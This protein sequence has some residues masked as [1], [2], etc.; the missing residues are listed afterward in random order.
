MYSIENADR[1]KTKK[2]A[3]K[4]VPAIATTTA[5]VAGLVST[6][7]KKGILRKHHL[8][9]GNIFT[10][11]MNSRCLQ[12]HSSFL[13]RFLQL[14]Q[15]VYWRRILLNLIV[16]NA[17]SFT[18]EPRCN[19]GPRDWQNFFANEVRYIEVLCHT[20]YYYC[21]K[22]NRSLYRA[23]TVRSSSQTGSRCL[24]LIP[25]H[26]PAGFLLLCRAFLRNLLCARYLKAFAETW[27]FKV[28]SDGRYF[29]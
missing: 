10:N 20:F 16:K 19:E 9:C 29:S 21:G 26:S 28:G 13:W 14:F 15:F 17:L 4:I 1:L 24:H 2:I 7:E 25:K 27:K 12:F 5:A 3:G 11:K 8:D 18:V 6:R 23:F 22:E